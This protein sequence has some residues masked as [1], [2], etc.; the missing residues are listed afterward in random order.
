MNYELIFFKFANNDQG[1]NPQAAADE[2]ANRP[3]VKVLKVFKSDIF[4][5][6]SLETPEDNLDTLKA[7]EP[8]IQAWQAKRVTLAPIVPLQSFGKDAAGVNLSIH[9]M[10]GV[11]KLH[12]KGVLGKGAVVAV[13]D[14]GVDYTHSAVRDQYDFRKSC[15]ADIE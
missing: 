11:D 7:E 10:T 3:G 15:V 9:H 14:T 4:H 2:L 6:A 12:A 8:V 13:V 5:G 1:T